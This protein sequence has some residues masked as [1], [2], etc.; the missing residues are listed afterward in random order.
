MM[1]N[2]ERAASRCAG[3]GVLLIWQEKSD[4]PSHPFP[5]KTRERMGHPHSIF[6]PALLI[7]EEQKQLQILRLRLAQKRA[8]LRSG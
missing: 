2:G 6:D 3:S 4:I 8:K 7:R 1:R 5:Q